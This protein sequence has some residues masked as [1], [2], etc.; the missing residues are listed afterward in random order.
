MK[1]SASI[2]LVI[3]ILLPEILYPEPVFVALVARAKASD[4][5][6][7]SDRQKEPRKSETTLQTCM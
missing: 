3:H 1:K 4:P 6:I 5:E 7:G 2:E